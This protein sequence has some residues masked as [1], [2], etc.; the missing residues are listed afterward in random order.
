M[1]GGGILLTT[2]EMVFVE[3][4]NPSF[5]LNITAFGPDWVDV[6]VQEKAPVDALNIAPVGSVGAFRVT[7]SPSGSVAE[8][9]N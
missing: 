4:S 2:T 3:V 1:L 9:V 5:A 8:I 6:G 7:L